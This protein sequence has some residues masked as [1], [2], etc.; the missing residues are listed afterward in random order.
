MS[1]P[2][3]QPDRENACTLCDLPLPTKPVEGSAGK[4][5]CCHGCAHVDA[6]LDAVGSDSEVGQKT[7]SA[8]RHL[9]LIS[10][11]Q[12]KRDTQELP[13]EIR[14]ELRL[15]V[16]GLACPSC[17]WLVESVISSQPGVAHAEVDY[18]S[19]TARI[20]YD[21]RKT[22]YD[23]LA[24]SVAGAGYGLSALDEKGG[25]EERRDNLRL[26]IAAIIG[27]NLM[28]LSWVGY[29]ATLTGLTGPRNN[30]IAWISLLAALPVVTWS[31][32]PL[33]R[34]AAAALFR[35][36]V[37]METLLSLGILSAVALSAAAIL[38][39]YPHIYL[40]TAT[41]L[42]AISLGGRALE[43][44]IKRRSSRE[45]TALL[46]FAP[47]KVRLAGSGRFDFLE[48]VRE[49]DRIIVRAGENVPLDVRISQE[50]IVR[51][52]LLT[53]EPHP[54][55]KQAGDVVL[56][57]S[58]V[59][60]GEL[61]GKVEKAAGK[62]TADSM[63]DRVREALRR[64]DQGSRFADR[65]AQGFVPLVIIVAVSAFLFH[66]LHGEE[67]ANAAMIAVSILVVS[68]PCAFGVATSAALSL[69]VL[70]L[71]KDGILVKD[72][73]A[74]EKLKS[75]DRAVFDKTGTLTVGNLTL[76]RTRRFVHEE[77]ELLFAVQ[78]MEEYSKHPVGAAL[79][80]LLPQN[81]DVKVDRVVEVPA[82][83]ITGTW[84]D[85]RIAAGKIDLFAPIDKPFPKLES[86]ATRIW[87]GQAG[88]QPAGFVDL[89][90]KLR[91]ETN[92]V[93]KQ[94]ELRKIETQLLSG[95]LPET[96]LAIAGSAGIALAEGGL[97]PEE[98]QRRIRDLRGKGIKVTYIGDGFNDAEALAEADVGIALASGAELALVSAPVVISKND[99]SGVVRAIDM[100]QHAVRVLKSNF[101]WAFAYNVALIPIAA[102]G[103]LQPIHA[104]G[105]MA[106]SSASVV[107]NSM[108]LRN[109]PV[110]RDM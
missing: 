69:A 4:R 46:Q 97:M 34:R 98:K 28:V 48:N 23:N 107:L 102:F 7:L 57:G 101:I 29:E 87:F 52:S 60:K 90:D 1:T 109:V 76:L 67:P 59:E 88:E 51:E 41:M 82:L 43:R 70:Q 6:I 38:T 47:T 33:Y 89:A 50:V 56:A 18:L 31:A 55:V 93:V 63:K 75:I 26:V 79:A 95:D 92:G 99:L 2:A 14:D 74:L 103:L 8:A 44:W 96:T 71:A 13:P 53:G 108:R 20:V 22:S 15:R 94:L 54:I 65:L 24:S 3:L 83:G 49:G 9:G 37:V 11:P 32:A 19:D 110:I 12:T 73:S 105:L 61:L 36:R 10:A 100:A 17:A 81:I 106:L 72:P 45:L 39:G 84:S 86:G 16:E 58:T 5:Y 42:V 85:Q 78:A 104:A 40:E 25:K 64:A 77:K 66:T 35:G 30:F 68:C 91:P 62:T 27:M 80:R 21:L